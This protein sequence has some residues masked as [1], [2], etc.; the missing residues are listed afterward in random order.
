MRQKDWRNP[1][2]VIDRLAFGEPDFGVKNFVQVRNREFFSFDD[3]FSFLW[4]YSKRSTLNAQRP[5]S[6]WEGHAL[7]AFVRGAQA[8]SLCSP[9]RVTQKN[10]P[11]SK[12][13]AVY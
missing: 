5:I 1:D 6:N 10:A 9:T 11:A 12:G 4:H 8:A 3:E 7:R 2:V 13:V